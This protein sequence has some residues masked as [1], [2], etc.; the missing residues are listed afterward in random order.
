M[1]LEVRLKD[2]ETSFVDKI[3]RIDGVYDATLISHQ[4]DIVA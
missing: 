2:S 4:G 3:M 1:T